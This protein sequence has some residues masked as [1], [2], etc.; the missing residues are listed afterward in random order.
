MNEEKNDQTLSLR[1][2]EEES[3]D[4]RRVYSQPCIVSTQ[5]IVQDALASA[6]EGED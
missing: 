2:N 6:A 4:T 5:S 1:R 3:S